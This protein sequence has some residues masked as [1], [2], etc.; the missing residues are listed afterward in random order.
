M[1]RKEVIERTLY[2]YDELSDSAKQ[3]AREWR[4]RCM[5]DDEWWESTYEDAE[6]VGI[7]I[8]SFYI[9]HGTIEGKFCNGNTARETAAN[10]LNNHGNTCETYK[11]AET[12][13][14]ALRE[15][16]EYIHSKIG[17]GSED[18][19]YEFL[20]DILEDYRIMLQREYDYIHSTEQIEEF[21]RDNDYEFLENG[22]I[23]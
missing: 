1:P 19:M 21:L 22:H 13:L 17:Y 11:T 15:K 8:T 23:V 3:F 9:D 14:K 4:E 18:L 5:S 10:I 16:D 6:E 7:K 20:D 12:F 2:Q